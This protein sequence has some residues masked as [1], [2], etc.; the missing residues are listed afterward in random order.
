MKIRVA[1]CLALSVWLG[2]LFV[3]PT[4][5]HA[6]FSAYN[7]MSWSTGELVSNITTG[8]PIAQPTFNL[9][10]YSSASQTPAQVTFSS[11]GGTC[12]RFGV[13]F[14]TPSSG[15]DAYLAFNGKVTYTNDYVEMNPGTVTTIALTGLDSTKRYSW[16]LFGTRGTNGA[17]YTGRL[18]HVTITSADLFTN[19]STAGITK[20]TT[21]TANDSGEMAAD[22]LDGKVFRFDGI[23]AGVDGTVSLVVSA[24]VSKA[25]I[26]AMML[27]E[28]DP[29]AG[30]SAPS[31]ANSGSSSIGTTTATVSGNL[32][33]TGGSPTA[34]WVYYKAGSDGGTVKGNWTSSQ[35][36]GSQAAGTVNQNL[37]GLTSN[38]TYYFRYYASN[39][40]GDAW[41]SSASTFTTAGGSVQSSSVLPAG[42]TWKYRDVGSLPGATWMTN[43]FDDSGWSS[44]PE[45]LGYGSSV[46]SF[47]GTTI[48]YG[49]D[50]ANKFITSYFRKTITVV[51]PTVLSN[52]HFFA[53]VDDGC[54]VY[55]NGAEVWRMNVTNPVAYSGYASGSI[56]FGAET[57]VYEFTVA[58][59][60][61][62]AGANDI[63]VETHQATP[64][65][66]DTLMSL[67]AT[68]Y[69]PAGV[70]TA[71]VSFGATSPRQYLPG[72]RRS[73]MQF[74]E[75][76]F[77]PSAPNQ[78]TLEFVELFNS[79]PVA[80][81]LNGYK[82][83]GDIN[84]TFGNV[85]LPGRGYLVIAK[86]PSALMSAYG[87]SGVLG[88]YSNS[89]ADSGSITL[90]D[91]HGALQCRN[92]YDSE[93]PWPVSTAGAGHSLVLTKPDYGLEDEWK[94]YS[95]SA[96]RGGNP[97]SAN[98]S[99]TNAYVLQNVKINEFLAHTDPPLEDF[100]ELYNAGTNTV[101]L[102]GCYLTDDKDDLTKYQISG[103]TTLGSRGFVSFTQTQLGF[104]LS[105][106]G[107]DI[108]LVNA[109]GNIILDSLQYEAQE[110]GVSVGRY[111][112]G[113]D[114]FQPLTART[115]GAANNTTSKKIRDVVI[116]EIMFDPITGD[117]DD[118]YVELYNKGVSP[119]DLSNW[120]FTDGINY[121]FP[122][123][124]T[125]SAGGYFVVARNKERVLAKFT[126]L[127]SATVFGDFEG[128]LSHSGERIALGK[129]DDPL[130]PNQDWVVMDEVRYSKHWGKWSDGGGSSLE[131][132]DAKS[133]N[134]LAGNWAGS[135]ETGKSAWVTIDKTGYVDGGLPN[136]NRDGNGQLCTLQVGMLNE[137]ESLVDEVQILR[138]GSDI[139]VIPNWDFESGMG[140]WKLY[141]LYKKSYLANEGYNSSGHS[142]HVIADGRMDMMADFACVRFSNA[143]ALTVNE[144]NITL[145]AKARWLAGNRRVWIRIVGGYMEVSGLL[146]VPANLGSPG[147]ANSVKVSNA[148]PTIE[149]VQHYP[150]LPTYPGGAT[151]MAKVTDPDGVG[152]VQLRYR[153]DDG[154]GLTT[155]NMV[156]TGASGDSLA[157]D[158]IYAGVIPGDSST[159]IVW[160]F[161]IIA[162]DGFGAATT[163]PPNY[164]TDECL[165]MFNQPKPAGRGEIPTTRMW[166][167]QAGRNLYASSSRNYRENDGPTTTMILDD[168]RAIYAGVSRYRGSTWNRCNPMDP[169]P[170]Y[171]MAERFIGNNWGFQADSQQCFSMDFPPYDRVM[172]DG[173]FNYDSMILHGPEAT[174]QRLSEYLVQR[175]G[176]PYEYC[177]FVHLYVNQNHKLL[178][179]Q[180]TRLPSEYDSD[181]GLDGDAIY[182]LNDWNECG[183]DSTGTLQMNRGDN[184]TP[185]FFNLRMTNFVSADG[186][187]KI[188]H[189]RMHWVRRPGPKQAEEDNWDP[190]MRI[191]DAFNF[192]ISPDMEAHIKAVVDVES[193]ARIFAVRHITGDW[194][195][196]GYSTGKNMQFFVSDTQKGKM[197]ANDL[198]IGFGRGSGPTD[199]LYAVEDP[200]ISNK[201]YGVATFKR[202]YDRQL[203]EWCVGAFQTNDIGKLAWGWYYAFVSNGVAYSST[204]Y[205]DNRFVDYG[206]NAYGVPTSTGT[207]GEDWVKRERSWQWGGIPVHS[208]DVGGSWWGAPDDANAIGVGVMKPTWQM[209]YIPLRAAQ[210]LSM[211]G[212]STGTTF[213]ITS[214]NF[215]SSSNSAQITG[216]AS[217]QIDHLLVNGLPVS[218]R[219]TSDTAWQVTVGLSNG[220]NHFVVSAINRTGAVSATASC[221]ITY[222][223]AIANPVG[224]IRI[225]ELYYNPLKSG[226]GFIE[227]YNRSTTNI[228][229]SGW[230]LDGVD[231]TFDAD[232]VIPGGGYRVIVADKQVY[233]QLY[234]NIQ[235]VVGTYGGSL[236]NNGELL[237]IERPSIS[238]AVTNWLVVDQ[239]RYD[240][241]RPWPTEA[242]GAGYS[243]QLR[244]SNQSGM[245]VGNW[246]TAA[247]WKMATATGA[248]A[249]TR[250]YVYMNSAGKVFIDDVNV[251]QGTTPAVGSNKVSN[252]DFETGVI[253]PWHL[254]PGHLDS[255]VWGNSH[256]GGSYGL[257]VVATLGGS[258]AD[259]VYCDL[260]A[261][262]ALNHTLS[263]W[264]L[265]EPTGGQFTVRLSGSSISS[266]VSNTPNPNATTPGRANSVATTLPTIPPIYINEIMPQNVNYLSDNLGDKDP[267][268]ELYAPSNTVA[269]DA[270]Y[271]LTDDYDSLTKWAFPAGQSI[272]SGTRKTVWLDGEPGETSGQT[273]HSSFRINSTNG[274]LGL[275]YASGANTV[276]VDY[277]D[278]ALVG[279]DRSFGSYPEGQHWMQQ[280]FSIPSAGAA[281]NPTSTTVNVKINE[282]LAKNQNIL[283][284]PVG[285]A[286][287]DWFELYNAGTGTVDLSGYFLTDTTATTNKAEIPGGCT[288]AGG[289]YL[290]V[291]ADN[292]GPSYSS[293][294]LHVNF[295]LAGSGSYLGLF[296]PDQR[297]VD[298]ISYAS[299]LDNI[300]EG[301][302]PDGT[303]QTEQMPIPT[304]GTINKLFMAIGVT[305]SATPGNVTL[306]WTTRPG[307][308]YRLE[309]IDALNTTNWVRYLAQDTNV[310]ASSISVQVPSSA[311]RR[312][313]KLKQIN[314]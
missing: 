118:Q 258:S 306:S 44:G 11:V 54:V 214:G 201:F 14:V 59:S 159:N 215:T 284:N 62:T 106:H 129:P 187:K 163:N 259:S 209:Q 241:D 29:V 262:S 255:A 220:V 204:D 278:Y 84:Y 56:G 172:G 213:A 238:G 173:G 124:A 43:G 175:A 275:V 70:S 170:N 55:V 96:I 75:I 221:D 162:T 288:I 179:N 24:A 223:G 33:S 250:L 188:E 95:Q 92:K 222:N 45:P 122:T 189:Y 205:N 224:A 249:N 228:D 49:S 166:L 135:V 138:N 17:G 237:S 155:V 171:P 307:G 154:S 91:E 83:G 52:L 243:L 289:G 302:F 64:G 265:A 152:S 67:W 198:D 305:T 30:P 273:A 22:N 183:L 100:I 2:T 112:D 99:I 268:A 41:A 61:F 69:P 157:G 311:S 144:G 263:Y 240:N 202:L 309:Y 153:K 277:I 168:A 283:A 191:V 31:I 57:N 20:Y 182:L 128:T 4:P 280:V 310:N 142:L 174:C 51:N 282:W 139:S 260:S 134:N 82:I 287:D 34:V 181:D 35:S 68:N 270:G 18:T 16:V 80:V 23:N 286:M 248:P 281:N 87:I 195:G 149:M 28:F 115:S 110:N 58:S 78:A 50:G 266:T 293:G 165:V 264:Y 123:G 85:T 5:S 10:D 236:Q 27:Q 216:N 272:N 207:A 3:N 253:Q 90:S 60:Y 76:M 161:N 133:D 104:G 12:G 15:S 242:D 299:Q 131:L 79:E 151:V 65:S 304:P 290:I 107:G 285:G 9:V 180:D 169:V 252:G 256:H 37:T 185:G 257:K 73:G 117:D 186:L 303:S 235:C 102:G 47:L 239:V 94:A 89:L 141:G 66:S 81:G 36:L 108:Y 160:A 32:S 21:T 212:S 143:N 105:M 244:D 127:T 125:I 1:A 86:D 25:Y 177:R 279:A 226:A 301:R 217:L 230:R 247:Q 196:Y 261:T 234:T 111:P 147:M 71:G 246:G 103:G 210:V 114:G 298:N 6:A 312:M 63:A 197:L 132:R 109:A 190:L 156:D 101:D 145:R 269:L 276:V 121:T 229:V 42:S 136:P 88:P 254:N 274:T 199:D 150:L 119:V 294:Q 233:A 167:T 200:V 291:W 116:N 7:D 19:N 53:M 164:P 292:T 137:G 184:S 8:S 46:S 267:W 231:F 113:S 26:C 218:E 140:S 313:F 208:V 77:H 211:L 40:I 245:L 251:V 148:G 193:W 227:L 93:M 297:L 120:R 130:L 308:Q 206:G 146:P 74:S 158:G 219:W 13:S 203:Y 300:S 296:T 126:N 98:P 295:K 178:L 176:E 48:S 192:P 314:P 225:N 39:G 271:Y 38:T 72:T 97:G 194:D 232:T